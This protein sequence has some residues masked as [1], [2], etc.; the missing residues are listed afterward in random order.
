MNICIYLSNQPTEF[1]KTYANIGSEIASFG[2]P[3]WSVGTPGQ[4]DGK[5]GAG[6][7]RDKKKGSPVV[8]ESHHKVMAEGDF[9]M[10]SITVIRGQYEAGKYEG[11]TFIPGEGV[12][13]LSLYF[14]YYCH[15]EFCIR[16]KQSLNVDSFISL[17]ISLSTFPIVCVVSYK[18]F[19]FL[20][21]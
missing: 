7:Q 10:Y 12:I 20:F 13:F 1:L 14:E 4:N 2:G 16:I 9:V 18:V 15:V 5:F 21:T 3:D 17:V 19:A 6:L 8:P 11:E